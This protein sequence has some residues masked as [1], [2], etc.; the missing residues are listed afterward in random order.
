GL[1]DDRADLAQHAGRVADGG[2]EARAGDGVAFGLR[3]PLQVA[4]ELLAFLIFG[5]RLT[6]DRVDGQPAAVTLQDADDTVAG[7]RRAALAE[8]GGDARR[9][10]AAADVEPRR[11]A[12]LDVAGRGGG[13]GLRVL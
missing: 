1:A 2:G 3:R 12:F 5:E 4:P 13:C 10:A 8:L 7:Q 11:L 9:Q 6:I